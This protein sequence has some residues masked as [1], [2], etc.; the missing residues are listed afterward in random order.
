MQ[1]NPTT[2]FSNSTAVPTRSNFTK[3]PQIFLGFGD[4]KIVFRLDL[5]VSGTK[6]TT[7]TIK[8]KAVCLCGICLSRLKETRYKGTYSLN[9][10]YTL[11][12]SLKFGRNSYSGFFVSYD[13]LARRGVHV[14]V[15]VYACAGVYFAH[16]FAFISSFNSS[17]ISPSGSWII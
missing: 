16:I 9:S 10:F 17:K 5:F 13:V 3:Q 14:R 12:S 15:H 1:K 4:C 6:T 8:N 11:R 7:W 2:L